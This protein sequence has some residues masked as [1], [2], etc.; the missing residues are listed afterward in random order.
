[1]KYESLHKIIKNFRLQHETNGLSSREKEFDFI[2][3]DLLS[4]GANGI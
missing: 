4:Q 1:M 2:S 3:S